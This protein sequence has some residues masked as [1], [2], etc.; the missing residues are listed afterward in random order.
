[1]KFNVAHCGLEGDPPASGRRLRGGSC[2]KQ[3]VSHGGKSRH[4]DKEEKW[5]AVCIRNGWEEMSY[6]IK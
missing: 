4:F 5:K 2:A 6:V 1:M 3:R